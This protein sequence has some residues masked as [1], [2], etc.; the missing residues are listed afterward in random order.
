MG[1]QVRSSSKTIQL[2]FLGCYKTDRRVKSFARFFS[3]NGFHTEIIY[4]EPGKNELR[5]WNDGGIHITQLPIKRSSGPLMFLEY[6]RKLNKHLSSLSHGHSAFACD[7]YSLSTARKLKL[8]GQTKNVIYDARELYTELPTVASRIAVKLFWKLSEKRGLSCTDRII[9]T[10]PLDADAIKNVHGFLPRSVLVR[11]LPEPSPEYKKN[12]YL[13]DK[14][15]IG[16]KKI[17]VYAGGIQKDRGLEEMIEAM[18]ELQGQ[19]SF[20]MI[21]NGLLL[22]NLEE[23]IKTNDLA[24]SVYF[25]QATDSDELLPILASADIGLALINTTS[26]SY[27]LALP[28]KVF[29][30]FQAGLPVL[31][32]KMK[33]VIDLFPNERMI[34]FVDSTTHDILEGLKELSPLVSDPVVS[35]E[36]SERINSSFTF[37]SDAHSLLSFLNS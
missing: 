11:N 25:H 19:F 9:A 27:E 4:G 2:L 1:E 8:K 36:I 18:K 37:D 35:Q 7:L 22:S 3:R 17:L 12:S 26:G 10:A 31:S 14:Y 13:R 29:E 28:S 6:R 23:K 33:Q 24:S 20:V 34:K 15:A 21:G 30:Y 32:S 16:N 5:T